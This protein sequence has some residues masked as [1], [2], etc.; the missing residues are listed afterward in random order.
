MS[1]GPR[2]LGGR[3]L[4][5]HSYSPVPPSWLVQPER[6]SS[7]FASKTVKGS[8]EHTLTENIDYINNP[9]LV[10]KT[11][12]D[13]PGTGAFTWPRH[14]DVN[15]V[16]GETHITSQLV[17]D[18]DSGTKQT[19]ATGVHESRRRYA[20]SFVSSSKRFPP[21]ALQHE[22]GPGSYDMP[23]STASAVQTRDPK[24][25][26]CS[27]KSLTDARTFRVVSNEPPDAIQSPLYAEVAKNW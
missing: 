26:S 8:I 25:A 14:D 24:R 3:P 7:A 18:V 19:L 6:E 13:A 2:S 23:P 16:R 17:Y 15:I 22:L 10:A 27:F 12:H 20:S 4:G 11:Q 9:Q 1:L 21:L 5:P